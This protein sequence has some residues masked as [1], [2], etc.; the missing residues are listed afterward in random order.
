MNPPPAILLMGPTA[1]GKTA[2]AMALAER[3]PVEI[4][5]V[6]S[7]LVYRGLDI[8]SAKPDAAMQAR[9]PHHLIDIL[10]P[11]ESYSAARFAEDARRLIGE[12]RARDRIPLLVGGTMLYFRAL[13]RGLS[14]LPSASPELR[15]RIEA[16]AAGQ[17]WPALHARLA[18]LDPDSAARLHP[19][20]Q[21]RIQRALE[22]I[23]LTGMT[24]TAFYAQARAAPDTDERWCRLALNLPA[25]GELHARIAQRFHAMIAQ[26]FV[27]EV[28]R[29]HARGDLHPDLP[30]IRAV[31][32]RQIWGYLDGDYG[33]DEAIER[34]IAATRQFAKRQLTWLRS[35]PALH[36]LDPTRTDLIEATMGH[37]HTLG[38]Q[39]PVK[40]C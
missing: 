18:T 17:G 9:V 13:T 37:L 12:I 19:N 2:L 15:R 26:G 38:A 25:R 20:D 5:S 24:P 4:I 29:L 30:A 23:E 27:E 31:G 40:R 1:S 22:I 6:D 11:A 3:L 10:D 36:W 14:V 21:Q 28:R 32:Y 8:G 34:G 7:A 35:E 39:D 16:E 33:L